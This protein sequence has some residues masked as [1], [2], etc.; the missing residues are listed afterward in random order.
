MIHEWR[1][2]RL[3]PG[4][5][6]D[7]L[8]LLYDRGLPLVTQHLPL[9]GYW[10]AESGSLNTIHH[11]W[12]YADWAERE[13][14]RAGLAREEGWTQGF[15][16]AAFALVEE[17][18]NRFLR[19]T[20]GSPAFDAA[21]ARRRK[22]HEART[23][24]GALFAAECAAL[25]SGAAPEGATALWEPLSGCPQAPFAL[26]PRRADPIP[27]APMAH[28]AHTVLRPLAFSPL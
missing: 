8:S 20:S 5:A 22:R 15:V 7:Y 24:G 28:A 9:M 3:K 19:L 4:A 1:T 21:L 25:V 13:A 12:S 18:A 26:L 27:A 2:Y 16:P 11:L 10:L 23:P 17:Q 14:S 6:A